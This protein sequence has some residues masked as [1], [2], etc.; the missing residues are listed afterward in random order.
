MGRTEW[1]GRTVAP[2][3]FVLFGVLALIAVPVASLSFGWRLGAMAGFDVAGGVF[4]LSTVSLFARRADGMR[5]A[6]QAN[7]ANRTAL[8]AITLGVMLVVLI[9]V[10]AELAQQGAPDRGAIWLILAT[11]VLVWA[12]S[13]LVFALH[14]A[15]LFYLPDAEGRDRQ[16]L[17]F[18]DT[19]EPDYGD[20]LYFACTLGMTFQTSDVEVRARAMR[21]VVLFHSLA[22][23]LFNLGV[24]AFTINVLGGG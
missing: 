8:L 17:R 6:A 9:S 18:P 20:F 23:F 12:F 1:V 10:A 22:A 21:R 5:R 2:P 7:D 13:N 3:R 19:E 4:L 15:H 24:V 11:L 16:G 14:Y